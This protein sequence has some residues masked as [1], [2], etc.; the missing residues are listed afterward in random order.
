M[1]ELCELAHILLCNLVITVNYY[2][3]KGVNNITQSTDPEVVR[4][5]RLDYN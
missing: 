2:F 1:V 3:L 4:I 5:N